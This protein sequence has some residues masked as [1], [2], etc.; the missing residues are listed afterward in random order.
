MGFV[1]LGEVAGI[2]QACGLSAGACRGR[3]GV[4]GT[5]CTARVCSS[6]LKAPRAHSVHAKGPL[7]KPGSHRQSSALLAFVY[8][9][10]AEPAGQA[11]H[12]RLSW[13]R[14]CPAAHDTH[15]S[16]TKLSRPSVRACGMLATSKTSKHST[17]G[18]NRQNARDMGET[19]PKYTRGGVYVLVGHTDLIK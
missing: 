19:R 6:S 13:S 4:I 17:D 5:W 3:V 8:S 15:V 1:V 9:N 7:K 2:A 18:R 14:Y 10:V 12:A 16:G 11:V